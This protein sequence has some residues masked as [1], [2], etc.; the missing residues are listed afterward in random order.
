MRRN[1]SPKAAFSV[2]SYA[3]EGA[4]VGVM[5][6]DC[7]PITKFCCQEETLG[8]DESRSSQDRTSPSRICAR[9]RWPASTW[10]SIRLLVQARQLRCERRTMAHNDR[11]SQHVLY[12]V[13][14][15]EMPFRP[16]RLNDV[17]LITVL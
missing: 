17:E 1:A 9:Y 7:L 11:Q 5:A 10:R 6:Q 14:L 2:Q 8:N 12:Q 3:R 16:P 13:N 15:T 4:G